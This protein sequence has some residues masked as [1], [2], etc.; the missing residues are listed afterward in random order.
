MKCSRQMGIG[1]VVEA[2]TMNDQGSNVEYVEK[3]NFECC[4]Q[5]R[6][7]GTRPIERTEQLD[8]PG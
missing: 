4:D 5:L 1:F 6:E 7:W 2:H 8:R 3:A